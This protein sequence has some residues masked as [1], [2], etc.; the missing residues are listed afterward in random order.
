MKT[1]D[2]VSSIIEEREFQIK[3]FLKSNLRGIFWNKIMANS[4]RGSHKLKYE[5]TLEA[6]IDK[7]V[8]IVFDSTEV[9]HEGVGHYNE[10]DIEHIRKRLKTIVDSAPEEILRG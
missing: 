10:K 1:T 4:M 3:F 7:L 8:D 6:Q 2:I 5:D 9:D